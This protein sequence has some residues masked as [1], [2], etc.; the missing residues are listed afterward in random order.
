MK[1]SLFVGLVCLVAL[2]WNIFG[3][4]C[5]SFESTANKG[6]KAEE[7][8][9]APPPDIS[10]RPFKVAEDLLE[11]IKKGEYSKAYSYMSVGAKA[12]VSEDK[13]S[14]ELKNYMSMASTKSYY[15]TRY[16]VNEKVIGSSKAVVTVEDKK[17]PNAP[18]WIWEFEKTSKG[19]KANN[20]DLPPLYEYQKPKKTT[21]K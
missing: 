20:I 18:Q 6:K 4:D 7:E 19:W 3:C 5:T 1:K 21:Q 14:A 9:F 2:S 12:K 8:K 15:V 13:F 16:V 10:K 11:S 17:Y